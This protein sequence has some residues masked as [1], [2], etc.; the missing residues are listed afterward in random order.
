MLSK[1][2]RAD[3]KKAF[4][5]IL[6]EVDSGEAVSLRGVGTFSRVEKPERMAR[7]PQTGEAIIVAARSVLKFKAS[8][9]QTILH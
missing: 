6:R 5:L 2:E 8:S 9:K 1:S 3:V 4:D 7:N